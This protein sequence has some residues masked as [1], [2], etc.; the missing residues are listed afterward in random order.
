MSHDSSGIQIAF[1]LTFGPEF[2]QFPYPVLTIIGLKL[3]PCFVLRRRLVALSRDHLP[4]RNPKALNTIRLSY[5]T[6][7]VISHS[8][9]HLFRTCWKWRDGQKWRRDYHGWAWRGCSH[10]APRHTA[11]FA[12]LP[13]LQRS[14]PAK[15]VYPHVPQR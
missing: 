12:R 10:L 7:N 1:G 2:T 3:G 8:S 9:K 15:P 4:V 14:A 13:L 5:T 6:S 11:Y